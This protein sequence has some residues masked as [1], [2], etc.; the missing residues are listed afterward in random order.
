MAVSDGE[1]ALVAFA[2]VRPR[3]P[4]AEPA[5]S[6]AEQEPIQAPAPVAPV[7]AAVAPDGDEA[8]APRRRGRPR[9]V[10]APAAEA[11]G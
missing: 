1:A 11:E 8:P 10:V 6:V 5:A 9:K 3:R 4:R 7:E 2:P